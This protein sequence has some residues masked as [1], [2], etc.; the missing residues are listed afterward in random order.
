MCLETKLREHFPALNALH[1]LCSATDAV[2][3]DFV[4]KQ[5]GN[6]YLDQNSQ[7][8][9]NSRQYP[10]SVSELMCACN[11]KCV[12]MKLRPAFSNFRHPQDLPLGTHIISPNNDMINNTNETAASIADDAELGGGED[13]DL[14]CELFDYVCDDIAASNV[15][16]EPAL[17]FQY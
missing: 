16:G 8:L 6:S 7:S 4:R 13:F 3:Y 2:L 5:D 12:V 17:G 1:E 10:H 15:T 14:D 11:A 9:Y